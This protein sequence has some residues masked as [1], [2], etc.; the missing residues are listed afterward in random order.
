MT[1]CGSAPTVVESCVTD[2]LTR[3][4][5]GV[6]V[7]VSA[8]R[9]DSVRDELVRGTRIKVA[10]DSN[11]RP[12]YCHHQRLVVIDDEVAFVGGIDVTDLGRDRYPTPEHPGRGRMGWQDVD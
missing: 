8:V 11:E 5:A 9:R 2:H 10:L 7:P 1:L 3:A 6:P 12:M 4:W